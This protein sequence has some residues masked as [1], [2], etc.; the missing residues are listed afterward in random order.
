MLVI[1][2]VAGRDSPLSASLRVYLDHA[3]AV[4][5]YPDSYKDRVKEIF[6][7]CYKHIKLYVLDP[8][9]LALS[10]LQRNIQRDRDDVKYL[11]KA[12]PLD[13]ELLERR[14]REEM[15]PYIP[16]PDAQDLTIELWKDMIREEQSGTATI[17]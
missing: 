1:N 6:P 14:Y 17:T 11:A 10:K 12:I 3:T 5:Y 2:K 13:T 8:Y 15:R 9:D 16:S 7:S 4:Q